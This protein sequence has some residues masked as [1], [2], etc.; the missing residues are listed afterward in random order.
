VGQHSARRRSGHVRVSRQRPPSSGAPQ[1]EALATWLVWAIVV[2]AIT[3][4]YARVSP[5]E[6]YHVSRS[7]LDGGLSRALVAL[8]FP[9]SLVAIGLVLVALDTMPRRA[10]WAGGP[11]IALCAVT[12]WPGVVDKD[13]LDAR[14]VNVVPALGVALALGLSLA[15]R[16]RA[17]TDVAPRRPLDRV[18]LGM[19]AVLLVAS[20]PWLAAELGVYLPEVG[21]ITS[22]SITD[23]DGTAVAA[24]HL[25]HHHGLD[26]ALLAMTGLLLSR[27]RLTSP[28]LTVATSLYVSLMVGY[29]LVNAGQDLWGEQVVKR[30]WSDRHVPSALEPSLTPIWLVILGVAGLV[31]VVLLH[32]ARGSAGR[33]VRAA[34]A[35]GAERRG[36]RERAERSGRRA[37]RR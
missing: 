34:A 35:H 28:R 12:A 26:G 13:D 23:G 15:A 1:G 16:Q 20:L 32:E 24:V 11:A 4:T 37:A 14:P 33:G 7:G 3:V 17:G 9:V 29:G 30:G 8:N 5:G 31:L 36:Q 19:A 27:P 2:V 18:R 6:L 25:G 10:W 21:F 22:R